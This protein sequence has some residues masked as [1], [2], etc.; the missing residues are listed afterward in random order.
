MQDITCKH[1]K[2]LPTCHA[3]TGRCYGPVI[4]LHNFHWHW[5]CLVVSRSKESQI[6]WVVFLAYYSTD[7]DEIWTKI[8]S[9]S[10]FASWYLFIVI[11]FIIKRN[12][13]WFT[14]CI[15]NKTKWSK[16]KRT[17]N[18][19]TKQRLHWYA[20]WHVRI[21]LSQFGYVYHWTLHLVLILVRMVFIFVQCEKGCCCLLAA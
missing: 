2:F 10:C 4:V 3:C 1:S 14:A 21:N 16:N 13:Y 5:P 6:W 18:Q 20:V 19:P 11:I 17:D 7:R 9:K 12:Y 8:W 15:K